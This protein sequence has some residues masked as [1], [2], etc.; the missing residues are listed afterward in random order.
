MLLSRDLD[1]SNTIAVFPSLE[2]AT[3]RSQGVVRSMEMLGDHLG[4]FEHKRNKN[5]NTIIMS[6]DKL[7]IDLAV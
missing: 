4:Q 2:P 1:L 6:F 5:R 3:G 7:V